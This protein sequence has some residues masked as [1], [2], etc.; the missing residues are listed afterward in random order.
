MINQGILRVASGAGASFTEGMKGRRRQIFC[1]LAVCF[2]L[3][4]WGTAEGWRFWKRKSNPERD[5]STAGPAE[6]QVRGQAEMDR[7]KV[8]KQ[9]RDAQKKRAKDEKKRQQEM[10]R[11]LKKK[12]REMA[13][14]Q[15]DVKRKQEKLQKAQQRG[16]QELSRRYEGGRSWQFWRKKQRSDFFIS[17]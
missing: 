6:K 17:K 5:V 12:E 15:R 2:L 8:E 13:R 4:H 1:L 7:D 11:A 9:I 10:A 16:L 14:Q 3:P